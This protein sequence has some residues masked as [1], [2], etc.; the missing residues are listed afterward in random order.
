MTRRRYRI[1]LAAAILATAS[2]GLAKAIA[3]RQPALR[4]RPLPGFQID[5]P[6][7]KT[8][9]DGVLYRTGRLTIHG[10]V[11][12]QFSLQL[13]WEP[14]RLLGD[15]DADA[16]NR[17][18]GNVFGV[19]ARPLGPRTRSSGPGAAPTLAWA[20]AFGR[21]KSLVT[22][23]ECGARR[24]MLMTGSENPAVEQLHRR[25]LASLRCQPNPVEERAIDDVPVAFDLGPGWFLVAKDPEV[26][27][28]TNRRT[29][30]TA[31]PV[32]RASVED[33][34]I[35][36]LKASGGM[37]GIR[38]GERIG[39]DWRIETKDEKPNPGWMTMRPC[40]GTSLALLL[41]SISVDALGDDGRQ[42]LARARCRKPGEKPQAWPEMPGAAH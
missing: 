39:D 41:M 15:E 7:G 22:Q 31:R 6:A 28:L 18:L 34:V 35:A 16:L 23:T 5:L 8:I 29:V 20:V 13:E 2:C 24:V 14:G 9:E 36:R 26:L 40:P 1:V 19:E 21:V 33:D 17:F 11:P 30:L 32:T 3:D 42:W 38:I 12:W 37:P 27:E 10:T 25:V 4:T